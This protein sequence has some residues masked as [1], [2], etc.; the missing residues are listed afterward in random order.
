MPSVAIMSQN[1]QKSVSVSVLSVEVKG[2]VKVYSKVIISKLSK[3]FVKTFDVE[4]YS[5]NYLCKKFAKLGMEKLNVELSNTK[6]P[7]IHRFYQCYDC[8]RKWSSEKFSVYN[9]NLPR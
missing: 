6:I 9:R 3:Q 5:F 2:R 8:S 7:E 1:S 4:S